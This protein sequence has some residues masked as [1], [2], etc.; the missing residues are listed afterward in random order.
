MSEHWDEHAAWW[1]KHFTAG[2]DPEYE[3]QII[4]I[5]IEQLRGAARVLDVGCGEG[6]VARALQ[7]VGQVVGVD[8]TMAQVQVAVERGGA[9]RYGR[10]SVVAL[11]FLDG[12]F[13]AVC[14][15]L[16]LE[17]VD[18]LEAAVAEVARVLVPEGRLVLFLNHP[19]LQTPESGWIDDHTYNPPERYWRVGPYLTEQAFLDE[20]ERG[21]IIRFVH[22][23]LHRYVNALAAEGVLVTQMLEPPPPP[24]FVARAA[25]YEEA[26]DIPRLLVLV[27]RRS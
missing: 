7:G 13:D 14:V 11:P 5:A 2:A 19:M 1:Q 21:V 10:A 22:R 9:P 15:C 23:P 12:T 3:E 17:H 16:M 20:V 24:G 6:Q 4:P 8:L 27:G 25:E 26:G 18:D